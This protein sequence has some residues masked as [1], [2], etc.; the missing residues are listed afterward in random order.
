M[1]KRDKLAGAQKA[2]YNPVLWMKGDP[3]FI[4]GAHIGGQRLQHGVIFEISSHDEALQKGADS[5][6]ISLL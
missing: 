4:K 2:P 1:G 6:E 3:E 5:L